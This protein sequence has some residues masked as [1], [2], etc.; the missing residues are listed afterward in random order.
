MHAVLAFKLVASGDR[1]LLEIIA[2]SL[3]VSM[4]MVLASLMGLAIGGFL[5]VTRFRGRGAT[6]IIL[7]A[8]M[9]LPPVVVGL[10]VHL[11]LSRAGPSWMDGTFITI[12]DGNGICTNGS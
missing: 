12:P 8:L 5:A 3:R 11:H 1:D 2:L 7:N 4:A 6:L 9:G 10:L